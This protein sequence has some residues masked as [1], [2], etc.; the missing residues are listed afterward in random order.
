MVLSGVRKYGQGC[1]SKDLTCTEEDFQIAYQLVEVYREHALVMLSTFPKTEE[2]ILDKNKKIFYEALPS[3]KDF[4]RMEAVAIG[5]SINIKERTVGKYLHS[6][7][8]GLIEQ[9]IKY[10]PYWKKE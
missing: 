10:G 7:L 8:G 5:K 4:T 6:F 1:T 3:G 2:V 9:P